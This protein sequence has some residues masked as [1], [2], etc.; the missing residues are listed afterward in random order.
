MRRAPGDGRPPGRAA[1][2]ASFQVAAGA[3]KPSR[4]VRTVDA[5]GVAVAELGYLR[6]TA[7]SDAATARPTFPGSAP[8]SGRIAT[9]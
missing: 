9:R 3:V 7:D 8:W 2:P 5:D 4:I 1:S 6:S